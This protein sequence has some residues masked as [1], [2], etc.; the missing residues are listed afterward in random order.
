MDTVYLGELVRAPDHRVRAAA[1]RVVSQWIEDFRLG[2]GVA[3]P[4]SDESSLRRYLQAGV[5]DSHPRV[6]LE[7]TRGWA[8]LKKPESA[9]EA[10]KVLDQPMDRFLDF[11]LW[12]T[13]RD[14]KEAWLPAV[15]SGEISIDQQIPHWV[16]AL[17]AVE[18][19]EA[20][21][22]LMKVIQ[23]RPQEH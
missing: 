6:R 22:I 16:F 21:P 7:A 14:L 3:I 5:V 1:M 8:R 23:N 20:I 10:L 11:A 18:A 17:R 4:S 15:I 19:R 13:M 9:A 12:Q 2:T